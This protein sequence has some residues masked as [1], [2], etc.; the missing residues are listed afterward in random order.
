VYESEGKNEKKG[1]DKVKQRREREREREKGEF[2][3]C[4]KTVITV[5]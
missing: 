1:G 2:Y 4:S 3:N 5:K